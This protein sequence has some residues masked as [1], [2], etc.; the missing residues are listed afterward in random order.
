[1]NPLLQ[2]LHPYPFERLRELTRGITPSPAHRPIS[3]GIGE[4]RHPTPKLIED[5]LI[6]GFPG[7]SSYPATADIQ[8]GDRTVIDGIYYIVDSLQ[9]RGTHVEFG[10]KQTD[11]RPDV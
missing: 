2:R 1:M 4:P 7:L 9:D 6:A 11:E 3:L 5:A 10:L 8:K